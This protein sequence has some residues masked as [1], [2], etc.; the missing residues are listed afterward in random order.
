MLKKF[1]DADMDWIRVGSR[2]GAC[3]RDWLGRIDR[4]N[5]KPPTLGR[6]DG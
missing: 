6:M 5:K 2:T 1:R 3:D 4:G